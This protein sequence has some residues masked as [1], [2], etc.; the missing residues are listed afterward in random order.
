M[1][2]SGTTHSFI[3]HDFM[4][5]LGLRPKRLM[6]SLAIST[7]VGRLIILYWVC[8]GVGVHFDGYQFLTDLVVLFMSD[9]DII[10]GM[11]WMSFHRV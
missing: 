5:E 2:D 10:L 11:D 7:L 1:F 4:L 9:F 3:T 6:I 8:H